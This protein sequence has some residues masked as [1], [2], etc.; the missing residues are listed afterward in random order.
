MANVGEITLKGARILNRDFA[1]SK[2]GPQARQFS[3]LIDDPELQDQLRRDGVKLWISDYTVDDEPPKAYLNVR[4]DF[5]FDDVDIAGINAD[6]K[7][8]VFNEGNVHEL[9][10]AWI[11][12]SEMHI[13][14]NSY[15]SHGRKGVSAYCKTLI[16]W[17]MS[18]EEREAIMAERG[19]PNNPVR[20]KYKDIFNKRND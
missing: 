13:K 18:A 2:F 5:R 11:K 6:G 16:V 3:V 17:F 8:F 19:N 15:E 14:L 7:A 1:G 10:K 12:D 9:D 4:V 20:E